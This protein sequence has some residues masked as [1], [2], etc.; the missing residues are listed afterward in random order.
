MSI[1]DSMMNDAIRSSYLTYLAKS[2]NSK[3]TVP[4]V[5]KGQGKGLIGK[6]KSDSVVQKEKKKHTAPRKKSSITAD[7]NI[8]PDPDEA[9]KLGESISLTEAEEQEVEL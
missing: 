5:G 9:I 7:D 1:P 3:I 4:K 6:K 2:S 8:L